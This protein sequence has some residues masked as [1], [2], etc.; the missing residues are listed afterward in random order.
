ML[1][2]DMVEVTNND[3]TYC[4]LIPEHIEGNKFI[5]SRAFGI[6]PASDSTNMYDKVFATGTNL[7]HVLSM[8]IYEVC[9]KLNWHIIVSLF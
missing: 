2:G 5:E 9:F 6:G 1:Q 4:V 7:Y 3:F 8:C